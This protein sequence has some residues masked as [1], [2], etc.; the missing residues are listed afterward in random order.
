MVLLSFCSFVIMKRIPLFL[1]KIYQA[2]LAEPLAYLGS[3][4][5]LKNQCRYTPSC[6]EYMKLAIQKHGVVKG[7]LLGLWRIM[8]CGPWGRGGVDVP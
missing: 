4:F 1:L 8:R 2:L 3:V 5:G 7:G 6:S